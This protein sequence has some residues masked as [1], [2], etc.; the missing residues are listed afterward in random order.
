MKSQYIPPH[1]RKADHTI[2]MKPESFPSLSGATVVRS[3]AKIWSNTKSFSS[4][5][6]DWDQK[7][8]E[9]KEREEYE[10]QREEARIRREK[11]EERM[12]FTYHKH[13]EEDEEE[14]YDH[15]NDQT[16][17]MEDDGWTT[18]EKKQKIEL[19]PE[20]KLEKQQREIEQEEKQRQD[21]ESVWD[22]DQWDY[23][24]RRSYT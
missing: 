4:L 1:L 16:D 8:K 6:R 11:M 18:V 5:A 7:A 9:E 21:D 12:H 3:N 23:R 17:V 10:K 20:Q 14:E 13:D 19:T 22:A 15:D 2:T 24:D